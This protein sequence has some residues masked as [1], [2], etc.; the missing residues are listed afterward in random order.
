[1]DTC[2]MRRRQAVSRPAGHH[3]NPLF[4]MHD[5]C[6]IALCTFQIDVYYGIIFGQSP[7]L[8]PEELEL[9]LPTAF[10]VWNAFGI[11]I[12]FSRNAEEPTDRRQCTMADMVFGTRPLRSPIFLVEDVCL[13]LCG[14]FPGLWR[15]GQ[16]RRRNE[17]SAVALQE[18]ELLAQ[19]LE[20]FRMQ[21]CSIEN[22]IREP[23]DENLE[24]NKY[25][26]FYRSEIN[27]E[28]DP[29]WR[30][31]SLARLS[32]LFFNT[33]MLCHLISLQLYADTRTLNLVTHGIWDLQRPL[34]MSIPEDR[35]TGNQ[36]YQWALSQKGRIALMEA[37]AAL[38]A[39]ERFLTNKHY[40]QGETMDPISHVALAQA[41]MV[42]HAWITYRSDA[43]TCQHSAPQLV[44]A[45]S[46]LGLMRSSEQDQWII[47]GGSVAMDGV[48]LCKCSAGAWLDRFMSAMLQG[49]GRWEL[50]GVIAGNLQAHRSKS[51]G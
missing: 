28:R 38:A 4:L 48:M 23:S 30:E 34:T 31:D 13:S 39:Y 7:F 49:S 42:V 8:Q 41:A 45:V 15:T 33:T 18:S 22:L 36:V 51:S 46:T 40:Q 32:F 50:S 43:C 29:S 44:T 37:I 10:C 5:T 12:Y 1:M 2:E 20:A 6:S 9:S 27:D 25:L 35:N 17:I 11:P 47:H 26:R 24:L 16:I 14:T 21:L 3:G 19:R